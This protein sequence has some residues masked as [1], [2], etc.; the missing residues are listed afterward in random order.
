MEKIRV[1]QTSKDAFFFDWEEAGAIRNKGRIHSIISELYYAAKKQE[2][3][4]ILM[5]E[6]NS[7][8]FGQKKTKTM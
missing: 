1:R 5:R 8:R 4:S 6:Q 7:W 2:L 3:E